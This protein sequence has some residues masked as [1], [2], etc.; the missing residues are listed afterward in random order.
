M[1]LGK[2]SKYR[3]ELFGISILMIMFFHFCG[4]HIEYYSSSVDG[5]FILTL[6]RRFNTYIGSIGV[7]IFVF[8]SGMGLYYSFSKNDDM[9][10]FFKKRFKRILIPYLYV[11]TI[12]WVLKR[13]SLS[14][15]RVK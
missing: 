2:I 9:R 15:G 12:F 10:Q 4:P 3:E 13:C 8:L 6:E 7:E 1:G 5:S 11:G 14:L